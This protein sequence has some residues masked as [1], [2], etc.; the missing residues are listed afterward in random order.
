MTKETIPYK[1]KLNRLVFCLFAALIIMPVS[2]PA[3]TSVPS[4]IETAVNWTQKESPYI[5]DG[6]VTIAKKGF[7][8][9][10]PGTVV[11]FKKDAMIHVKGALYSKGS[12]ENPVRLIPDDGESFYEGIK[13]ETSYKNLVEYTLLIRG[14]LITEGSEVTITNNYILNA[15][16]VLLFHFSKTLIKDNY[17]YGNTY[18]IYAEGEKVFYS[19]SGNTFDRNRFA[20]YIKKSEK[21]AVNN[22]NFFNNTVNVTNYSR[23]QIDCRNNFWGDQRE[24]AVKAGIY[25]KSNNSKVGAVIYTPFSAVK[26]KLHQPSQG[27]ISLAKHYV[28]LK[29]PDEEITNFGVGAGMMFVMPFSP[30]IIKNL[31]DYSLGVSAE[32]TIRLNNSFQLGL[33]GNAWSVSGEDE[34]GTQIKFDMASMLMN[35]YWYMGYAPNVYFVPFARL[36]CGAAILS[37]QYKMENDT[38]KSNELSFTSSAGLG[39]EWFALKFFSIKAEASYF[40]TMSEAGAVSGLGASAAG[41][42][43]FNIPF[44]LNN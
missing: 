30:D 20:V 43:Y 11:R 1:I 28:N 31:A 27:F 38:K 25:D 33:L 19:A 13:F 42:V 36:G 4:V 18:G 17:F 5:V 2:A 44:M 3:E 16:G 8:T 32:F 41:F 37:T 12:P 23:R 21:E 10:N 15:T 26:F 29:R 9:I 22:N 39:V 7:V 40:Y 35:A 14:A 24:P 34:E 6:T